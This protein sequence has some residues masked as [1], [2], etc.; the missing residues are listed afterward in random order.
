MRMEILLL[1]GKNKTE[2]R[3]NAFKSET[4]KRNVNGINETEFTI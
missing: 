4:M 2:K 1:T 3:K